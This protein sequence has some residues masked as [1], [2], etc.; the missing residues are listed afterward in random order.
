M[1]SLNPNELKQWMDEKK[2]IQIIDVREKWEFDICNIPGTILSP[3]GLLQSNPPDVQSLDKSKTLVVYCH[4]GRRS[5][6]GC[7]ILASMGFKDLYNLTGGI[8]EYA[9]VVEPQMEKY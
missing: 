1:K 6:M 4:H 9:T 5:A 2:D 7:N 3:L 8:D